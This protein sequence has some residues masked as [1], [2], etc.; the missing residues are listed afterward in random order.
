MP[1]RMCIKGPP[2]WSKVQHLPYTYV[3]IALIVSPYLK[4]NKARSGNHSNDTF[5]YIRSFSSVL[6][7]SKVF[8]IVGVEDQSKMIY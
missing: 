2:Q 8:N 7:D 4:Q 3:T 1:Q 5:P 6:L